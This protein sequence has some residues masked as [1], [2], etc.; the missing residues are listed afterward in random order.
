MNAKKDHSDPANILV[1]GATGR[2]GRRLVTALL[3]EGNTVKALVMDKEEIRTITPGVIPI[4][5]KLSDTKALEEACAD[6][7][8]VF[9]L[10][11]AL[12]ES[13]AETGELVRVNVEGT[14]NLLRP[15][16]KSGVQHLI[17]TSAVDVYGKRRAGALT[18]ESDTRPSG[19][20]GYSKMLAEK[21]VDDSGVPHTILRVGN[22]YGHGYENSFFKLFRAVKEEKV[23]IIGTGNN[24]LSLIN[25]DD[26]VR[27][28]MLVKDRRY[29]TI[30]KVYNLSDD[31][32]FTQSDLMN[33]AAEALGVEKPSRHVSEF[34][35]SMIA[36][37]RDLD[38]NELRLLT[39]DLKVDSSKIKKE[40]GFVKKVE[41]HEG[42]RKMVDDF[43]DASK[44]K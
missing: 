26:V 32:H 34:L 8:V 2:L 36:R 39:S 44:S 42:I 5:G 29:D 41:I 9:H 27:A 17:F 18:E 20:Y 23:A 35:V 4:I 7:D 19:K 3:E 22:I 37:Q 24:H 16:I 15:C 21:A 28:L 13:K 11:A 12:G 14:E 1:T 40:L 25:V 31:A 6:A 38:S 33:V 30:G 10:A 43:I